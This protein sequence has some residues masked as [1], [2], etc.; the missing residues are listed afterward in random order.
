MSKNT[1][2]KIERPP[3]VAIMGHVDH[4]K[5][6]LLDYIRSTNI[7]DGEAGGIT[8]HISAYEITHKNEEGV[9]KK[10]TF[11]DTPGHEAF[12]SMRERGARLADIAILIVSAEDGVKKQTLESLETI[13]SSGTPFFVAINKI[14]KPN[15]DPEKVKNGLVEHEVYLEG[16]GGDVPYVEISAKAGTNVDSL[17]STI[18]LLAELE[19]LTGT[20]EIAATGFVIE[21]D[22]NEKRGI[23]SSLVIKDGTLKKGMFIVV[24]NMLSPTKI[25]ENF[26]GETITEATFST[27]IQITGFNSPIKILGGS[28]TKVPRAG[29]A[30]FSFESKKEAE[31][32]IAEVNETG[33]DTTFITESEVIT[34]DTKLV[35]LIIKTDVLGTTEAVIKEIMKLQRPEVSFKIVEACVGDISERDITFA[36]AD[37]ETIIAGFN[38]KVDKKAID[39]N[40]QIGA[41]VKTFTIIYELTAWLEEELEA[42]RPRLEIDEEHGSAK[43]LAFFSK[44]K[45]KQVVGGSINSGS[46][47]VKDHVK[48]VRRDNEIG[49]GVVVGLQQNKLDAQI[50]KEGNQCGIL[51]ESKIDIAQGD[52]LVAFTKVVK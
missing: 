6:T 45:N 15:A 49:T 51:V 7:V 31:K 25:F 3:V 1:A 4:G 21:S 44:M 18:L 23:S 17:L 20:P 46:F 26:L 32:F 50:V 30:F 12:T 40:E 42:R 41:T 22:V 36:Q 9:D 2:N 34:G 29:E 14:D 19:E 35:P 11:L 13:K 48:I 27:P 43:I 39:A 24:N 38:V 37:K 16:Y 8:Q 10:I 52:V 5:S 33:E 47:S 28:L